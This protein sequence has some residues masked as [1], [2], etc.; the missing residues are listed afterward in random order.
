MMKPSSLEGNGRQLYTFSLSKPS[1]WKPFFQRCTNKLIQHPGR[2][3][4]SGFARRCCRP[5]QQ[6]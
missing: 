1:G 4:P 6:G 5:D 3:T 2:I